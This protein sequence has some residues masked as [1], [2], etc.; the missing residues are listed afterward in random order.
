ML[1]GLA[2][3]TV[4]VVLVA[5]KDVPEHATWI[6]YLEQSVDTVFALDALQ[7]GKAASVNMQLDVM[8]PN[9]WGSAV[10]KSTPSHGA[11]DVHQELFATVSERAITV[12]HGVP[13]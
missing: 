3:E 2:C 9:R 4:S 1:Q 7:V 5:H 12:H 8:R 10:D 6:T 11:L 13:E